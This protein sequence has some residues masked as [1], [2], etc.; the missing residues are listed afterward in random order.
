MALFLA[1]FRPP[2]ISR[3]SAMG[4]GFLPMLL[5]VGIGIS[6]SFIIFHQPSICFKIVFKYDDTFLIFK[7][8]PQEAV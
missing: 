3:F 8:K 2:H 1:N 6:S 7:H 5:A 4:M